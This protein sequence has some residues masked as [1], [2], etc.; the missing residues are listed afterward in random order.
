MPPDR[1]PA[2][3]EPAHHGDAEGAGSVV[4]G[5]D[6][7]SAAGIALVRVRPNPELRARLDSLAVVFSAFQDTLTRS[8]P[9]IRQALQ[10][11]GRAMKAVQVE[12]PMSEYD[13]G[14]AM[15]WSPLADG[16]ETPS[17]PA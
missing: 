1:T 2:D 14:D 7:A 9:G 15:R 3:R 6:P 17:C 16:E 4:V 13:A 8:A 10:E 12:P 5:L 11:A